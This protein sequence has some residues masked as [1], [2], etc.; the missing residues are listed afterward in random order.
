MGTLFSFSVPSPAIWRHLQVQHVS[1]AIERGGGGALAHEPHGD[2]MLQ[3]WVWED[4]HIGSWKVWGWTSRGRGIGKRQG[5]GR[6]NWKLLKTLVIYYFD[7]SKTGYGHAL[8]TGQKTSQNYQ[9]SG[10][11]SFNKFKIQTIKH[12][13]YQ[14]SQN[15]WTI[16]SLDWMPRSL[17]THFL[18]QFWDANVR[19][20][21]CVCKKMG[22]S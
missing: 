21:L 17:V 16:N 13:N 19:V 14:T 11:T 5:K 9:T 6:E 7:L 2:P 1:R 18:Q 22:C 8:E 3:A 20:C 10:S 15:C 12:S 4:Q